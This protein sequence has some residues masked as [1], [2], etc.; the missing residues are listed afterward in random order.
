MSPSLLLKLTQGPDGRK[1]LKKETFRSTLRFAC[2]SLIR[3]E[4]LQV[5]FGWSGQLYG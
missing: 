3:Y 2:G 4:S 5:A 1:A